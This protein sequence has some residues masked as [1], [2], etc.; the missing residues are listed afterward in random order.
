MADIQVLVTRP[1]GEATRWVA[2]LRAAGCQAQALPLIEIAP[3]PDTAELARAWRRR[4]DYRALMF[5]SS[6]AVTHFY[7]QKVHEAPASKAQAAIN[8][9]AQP[10][11]W[12][13]GPGTA[14]A[15]REAGVPDRLIDAPPP[16][17]GQFD[18][19]ALWVL[20]RRQIDSRARVLLVRGADAAGRPSGR[21]WLA[22]EVVAAGGVCDTVV[23]YRRLAPRLDTASRR[24]AEAAAQAP[25]VWLFSSAEAIANLRRELPQTSWQGARAVVTHPRIAERARDAGFGLVLSARPTLDAVIASIES[26][27]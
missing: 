11:C 16:Q 2:T 21:D 19:E 25:A 5:V 13:T 6:A 9:I 27:R 14:A 24:L 22:R 12:A 26:L 18:S 7:R 20:V 15:L 23:A 3:V 10:R 1:A 17:S 4:T 8:M